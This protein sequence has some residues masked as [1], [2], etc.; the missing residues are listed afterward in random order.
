MGAEDSRSTPLPWAVFDDIES[1]FAEHV[2]H[3]IAL[4]R[5][6][7]RHMY[8]GQISPLIQYLRGSASDTFKRACVCICVQRRLEYLLRGESPLGRTETRQLVDMQTSLIAK[9]HGNLADGKPGS[10]EMVSGSFDAAAIDEE[11]QARHRNWIVWILVEGVHDYSEEEVVFLM[12]YLNIVVSI[13]PERQSFSFHI[14]RALLPQLATWSRSRGVGAELRLAT[15]S[16]LAS[17]KTN[18]E[19]HGSTERPWDRLHDLLV[20]ML[21]TAEPDGISLLDSWGIQVGADLAALE[22]PERMAWR[23]IFPQLAKAT[24][25]KPS[26][27]WLKRTNNALTGIGETLFKQRM[28]TW[29]DH[30]VAPAELGGT[31]RPEISGLSDRNASIL[32]GFIWCCAS[33]GDVAIARAAGAITD[34]ALKN[35]PKI[36]ARNLL[37]G[38]AGIYALSSMPGML[39]AEQLSRIRQRVAFPKVRRSIDDAL[40]GI[41]ERIGITRDDIDDLAT[42]TFD[43]VNGRRRFDFPPYAAELMAQSKAGPEVQ[44]IG[45]DTRP[46]KSEPADLRKIYPEQRAELKRVQEDLRKTLAAQR[47]RLERLLMSERSWPFTVWRER[48]LDHP[49]LS[50]LSRRLIWRFESDGT[51][52]SGAWRD[53]EFVDM[54]DRPLAAALEQSVVRPWHPIDDVAETV[55]AWQ[56][57][58]E[59]L[60]IRQPFKQAHREIYLLTDAERATESYSNRFAGHLLRHHQFKALAQGRGWRYSLQGWFDADNT[61]TLELPRWDLAVEYFVVG[62]EGDDLLTDA[63]VH[64]F[65]ATD[66]VRF[67]HYDARQRKIGDVAPLAEIPPI[68]FTEVMRDV[69]LFVGVASVGADPTW[70]DRGEQRI[71][72][73]WADYAFGALSVSAEARRSMLERLM[74]KLAISARCELEDR[75]LVVRGNLRTYKIHLGSGNILMQPNNEYLCIVPKRGTQDDPLELFLPFDGDTL[76]STILSKALLLADDEKIIDPTITSQILKE[77]GELVATV[78]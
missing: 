43:L 34:A 47:D 26:T 17:V 40:N 1:R 75:F 77:S 44:W 70:H 65:V 76:L 52:V 11:L 71:R 10:D 41:A 33:R 14:E 15:E 68:V 39:G 30:Y 3:E 18:R 45:A 57:W 66:Q 48:Y 2:A 37:L 72:D 62:V 22:P 51:A 61:P 5:S 78:D 63:G 60:Q 49:L 25:G 19:A 42:P 9:Q 6:R 20:N 53:G 24:S 28:I 27:V 50:E 23:A 74:P 8:A 46:R 55:L 69:D 7:T 58:L 21:D 29:F 13:M 4:D 54:E 56:S 73:Y 38:N 12:D 35:L 16:L 64:L 32:R 59:R 36:G 67:R 31:A